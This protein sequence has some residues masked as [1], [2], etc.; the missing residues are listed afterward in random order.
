MGSR[1]MFLPRY[2]IEK[3]ELGCFQLAA[4]VPVF[5]RG[6]HHIPV[7]RVSEST[8]NCTSFGE[9]RI[10]TVFY[11]IA[12]LAIWFDQSKGIYSCI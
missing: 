10:Q 9:A 6:R 12:G 5:L 1:P 3:R 4:G 2:V 8:R 7:E 11:L